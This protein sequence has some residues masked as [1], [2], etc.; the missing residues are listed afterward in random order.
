VSR[1]L[2]ILKSWVGAAVAIIFTIISGTAVTVSL[3]KDLQGDIEDVSA[4]LVE[5]ASQRA[6]NKSQWQRIYDLEGRLSKVEVKTE[7]IT[8]TS[9]EDWGRVK[10]AVL[11]HEDYIRQHRRNHT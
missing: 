1:F 5:I 7:P 8:Q 2:E 10:D 11:R 9:W 6:T 3:Y 4:Q